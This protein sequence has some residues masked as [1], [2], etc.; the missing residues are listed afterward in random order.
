MSVQWTNPGFE[1]RSVQFLLQFAIFREPSI[2]SQSSDPM[3]KLSWRPFEKKRSEIIRLRGELKS[4]REENKLLRKERNELRPQAR[5]LNSERKRL[6]AR[7]SGEGIEIGALH[8]P[9]AVPEGV[10]VRYADLYT[11]EENMKRC[12]GNPRRPAENIVETDYVCD[13]E[14]LDVIGDE[15]QDFVIAIHMLEHCKDPIRTVEN[16]LR[17]TRMGGILYV[18]LPDKRYTFDFR[19]PITAWED[20]LNDYKT[21]IEIEP[22]ETYQQWNK[23]VNPNAKPESKFKAQSNI[24]FH[25]WT[26]QEIVEM[27]CR[28]GVRAWFPPASGNGDSIWK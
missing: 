6:A 25:V 9:L 27:F 8:K 17:V 28:D 23:F 7:L 1:S 11:R 20:I 13:G 19:R 18:A 22:I 12:E 4:V 24:H 10:T 26:M 5:L 14:K 21:R 2:L 16:F 15:T 3:K